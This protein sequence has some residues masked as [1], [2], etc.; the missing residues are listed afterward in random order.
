MY[1]HMTAKN[2][3]LPKW[4]VE[5]DKKIFLWKISVSTDKVCKFFVTVI[6]HF[7]ANIVLFAANSN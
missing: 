5:P 1:F 2:F 3:V 7:A 6:D 4:N